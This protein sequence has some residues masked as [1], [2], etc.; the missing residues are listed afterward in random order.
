MSMSNSHSSRID[1]M[2]M[3]LLKCNETHARGHLTTKQ[4]KLDIPENRAAQ[5][6]TDDMVK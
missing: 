2:K 4:V 1:P 3:I 6:K 5:V